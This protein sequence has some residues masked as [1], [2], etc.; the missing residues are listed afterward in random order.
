MRQEE[1][2]RE[3]THHGIRL[4]ERSKCEKMLLS[5]T[6]FWIRFKAM[7]QSRVLFCSCSCN[8]LGETEKTNDANGVFNRGTNT[9][10]RQVWAWALVHKITPTFSGLMNNDKAWFSN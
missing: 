1:A 2:T 5:L 9:L 4:V 6:R 3:Q 8:E 7:E 10:P